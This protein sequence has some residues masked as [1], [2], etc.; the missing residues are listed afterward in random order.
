MTD[1]IWAHCESCRAHGDILTFG[2]LVWNNSLADAI[3]RFADLGAAARGEADRNAGEHIRCLGRLKTAEMFWDTAAGQIWNHH[4]DVIACRLRELG[5]DST[6]EGCEGL[7]GVAHHDQVAEFCK[8]VGRATPPRMRENGPSL[9]L[10]YYDLPGRITGVLLVQYNDEFMSRRVFVPLTGIM[11]RKADA[12]Y[13]Q[14]ATTLLPSPKDLRNSYFVTDDPFWV[15]KAQC[16]QLKAGQRL[17]PLAASYAGPE[18]VSIGLNWQSFAPTARLF[19]AAMYTPEVISQ[20]AAA[21]GYVCIL[22]PETVQRTPQPL[23]TLHRLAAVRREAQTWQ[24]ALEKAL[25]NTN[26]MAAQSFVTKLTIDLNRL[27]HFF[28]YRRHKLPQDFC[29]RL[30]SQ[31][32]DAPGIPAKA[33]RRVIVIERDG[34]WWTH[35]NN[36]ICNARLRINKIVYTEGG[37]RLYVGTILMGEQEFEF[38]DSADKIEQMGLLAYAAQHV[39]ARGHLLIYDRPWNSK[40]HQTALR[41][42][43]PEIIRITGVAGWNEES[44]QFC[45]RDYSISNDGTVVPCLYPQANSGVPSFPEPTDVAPVTIHNLLTPSHENALFWSTFAAFAAQLLA[46]VAGRQPVATALV[47]SAFSAVL[48]IGDALQGF[49][50]RS[51]ASQR[52]AAATNL[53]AHLKGKR[54]PV[55]AHHAF[56]DAE[57]SRTVVRIPAAAL[58]VR[59]AE[60]PACVA[61]SYGWQFIRGSADTLP[62]FSAMRYILPAYIQRALQNRMA[63]ASQHENLARA[64]LEDLAGWLKDI[65]GVTFN[66]AC[67]TNRLITPDR[68]HE[69]LMEAVNLGIM[70]GKIDVLPRPR[71]KSQAGNYVLR[72]KQHWW[73]NQKAINQYCISAGGISPNWTEVIHRL[74]ANGLLV[75]E[76]SVQG[77]PG[78]LVKKDWCDQFWSDYNLTDVRDIG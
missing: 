47:G 53:I 37:G 62:D 60:C 48:G 15:I 55:L 71:R 72:N 64:I 24:T 22:P 31:V 69:A 63:V 12:G 25:A 18:A 76:Q 45:F 77:M 74:T 28:R 57:M 68:A 8:A 43:T 32:E 58:F 34:C 66:L 33:Q 41:F 4:D 67:A 2:A 17:L 7:I 3:N 73:L 1:G 35:T 46:P 26:E 42:S 44:G 38:A 5:L 61:P 23:R 59:A 9:V 51:T 16:T 54:W 39:A 70:A 21:K 29:A 78:L 10:P 49:V 11:R 65:Y 50:F 52:Q 6:V 30:L 27:Q 40:S 75:D 56:N 13:F 36:Q 19:H 14:L 20:A